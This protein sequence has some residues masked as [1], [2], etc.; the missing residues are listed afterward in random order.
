L[1]QGE[2]EGVDRCGDALVVV[3]RVGLGVLVG[4]VERIGV[5]WRQPQRALDQRDP[6]PLE[7]GDRQVPVQVVAVGG[8]DVVAEPDPR[9]GDPERHAV[10]G[11]GEGRAGPRAQ[12]GVLG[13]AEA[14]LRPLLEP[15]ADETVIVIAGDEHNLARDRVRE[16][17]QHGRRQLERGR[18]RA[19]AQLDHVAE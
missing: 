18:D 1:R 9:V 3:G 10:Q 6:D 4:R 12:V 7:R 8:V 13:Q 2:E 5:G 16:L 14:R 11:F 17:S 19:I 15:A